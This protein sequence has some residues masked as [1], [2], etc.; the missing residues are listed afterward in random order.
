MSEALDT[1]AGDQPRAHWPRLRWSDRNPDGYRPPRCSRSR[2]AERKIRSGPWWTLN[3]S[4]HVN[5]EC[6]RVLVK[7]RTRLKKKPHARGCWGAHTL[8][9]TRMVVHGPNRASGRRRQAKVMVRPR[10]SQ[11]CDEC[12]ESF[13]GTGKHVAERSHGM[14][15]ISA[16]LIW[17]TVIFFSLCDFLS[18]C[19]GHVV[20]TSVFPSSV[21]ALLHLCMSWIGW[22]SLWHGKGYVSLRWPD[23]SRDLVVGRF[24]KVPL[25]SAQLE[26]N[27]DEK[28][29]M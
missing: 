8:A 7:Q 24:V 11:S 22:S 25:W 15:S 9:M 27:T 21:H 1:C 29:D 13:L 3:V 28:L 2:P 12:Q 19:S 26:K 17:W 14:W 5:E 10:S 16:S 23:C 6:T 18:C 4:S 20:V